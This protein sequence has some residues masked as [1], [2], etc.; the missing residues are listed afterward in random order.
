M[1]VRAVAPSKSISIT[2]QWSLQ[3]SSGRLTFTVRTPTGDPSPLAYEYAL[4]NEDIKLGD[5][6][7]IE[8]VDREFRIMAGNGGKNSNPRVVVEPVISDDGHPSKCDVSQIVSVSLLTLRHRES[9]N[10]PNIIPPKL[11]ATPKTHSKRSFSHRFDITKFNPIW[12]AFWGTSAKSMTNWPVLPGLKERFFYRFD[13]L[14]WLSEVWTELDT[15]AETDEK[16]LTLNIKL[17]SDGHLHEEHKVFAAANDHQLRRESSATGWAILDTDATRTKNRQ[18][19]ANMIDFARAWFSSD[20]ADIGGQTTFLVA[21]NYKERSV[22][23]RLWRALP[24]PD[25]FFISINPQNISRRHVCISFEPGCPQ[26]S[27]YDYGVPV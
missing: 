21:Y 4:T 7:T 9:K 14:L 26:T 19:F 11:P 12:N 24:S 5:I 3:H 13:D 20:G 6:V 23:V 8:G 27:L 2:I 16:W 22:D 25:P 15:W 10:I 18:A 17:S 1:H